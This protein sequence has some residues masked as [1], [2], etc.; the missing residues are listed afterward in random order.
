MLIIFTNYNILDLQTFNV[1][2]RCI[3]IVHNN[4]PVVINNF[5]IS[6]KCLLSGLGP[7]NITF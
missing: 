6:N 3:F 7:N 2:K 5:T 4:C 1:F